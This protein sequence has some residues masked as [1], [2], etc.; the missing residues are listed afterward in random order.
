M[1]VTRQLNQLQELDIEIEQ[2]AQ[3]LA[4]KTGRLGN[5]E[6]LDTAAARGAAAQKRFAELLQQRHDAE[7]QV[8]DIL[9]KIKAAEKEL[10][11]GKIVNPKELANL[12]HEISG[13]KTKNDSLQDKALNIIELADEAEKNVKVLNDEYHKT[14]EAWQREQQ[15]LA[16]EIAQ[17]KSRL[18]GLHAERAGLVGQI[19][20]Q[21]TALYEKIRQQKK[22]AVARVE[23]GICRACRISVSASTLQKARSGL[24][25]QCGTCGRILFIS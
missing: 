16:V 11:G 13:L 15:Q 21:A 3:T 5:R 17:L 12:Q 9:S 19:E 8:D 7:W 22:P 14:E 20:P 6:T 4:L 18:E 25:V 23:Q 24:P 1:E 10:Y 2:A